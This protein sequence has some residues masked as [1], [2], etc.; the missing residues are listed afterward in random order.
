MPP[1]PPTGRA[2]VPLAEIIDDVMAFVADIVYCTVTT[3]DPR[4]RPRSRVMHPIFE[5]VDDGLIGWALTGRSPVKTRHLAHNPHVSCSY[6]SPAQNTVAIDC[7]ATWV[8]E[9]DD[10][11]RG[12]V[13]SVFTDT[14]APLGWGELTAYEPEGIHHRLFQ[15]LRLEPW[16][17]QVL[18]A[19]QLAAGDVR[20]RVWRVEA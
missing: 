2:T 9:A 3:V 13:W 18:R 5:R 8:D 19:E 10:V 11:T 6:W 14:P 7:V 15:P 1:K 12:H 17:I 4:G 16:R 20:P